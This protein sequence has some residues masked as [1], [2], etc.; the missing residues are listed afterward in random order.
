MGAMSPWMGGKTVG[1]IRKLGRTYIVRVKSEIIHKE[2]IP[3][4][5]EDL[6]KRFNRAKSFLY[7]YCKEHGL[8]RNQY[9]YMID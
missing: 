6:E 5:S 7:N 3:I 4:E 2:N 1:G 8:L 9:R